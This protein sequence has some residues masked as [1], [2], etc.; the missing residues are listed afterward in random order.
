MVRDTAKAVK[1]QGGEKLTLVDDDSER[2]AI[3]CINGKVLAMQVGHVRLGTDGRIWN[4]D[5]ALCDMVLR[6]AGD[7]I[8]RS[9]LDLT[10]PPDRDACERRMRRLRDTSEPYSVVKRMM[11]PDGSPIWVAKTVGIAAFGDGPATALATITRTSDLTGSDT[12]LELLRQAKL[13]LDDIGERRQWMDTTIFTDPPTSILFGAYVAE[14]EGTI[15][16][17]DEMAERAGVARGVL[18]RWMRAMEDQGLIEAEGDVSLDAQTFGY[19]LTQR[20]LDRCE[21]YL[22]HRVRVQELSLVSA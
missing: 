12:P 16:R 11:L 9:I 14:A 13:L 7:L 22:M 5:A 6:T 1:E 19:R 3:I 20:S 2:I 15:A 4:V 18:I 21:S 17:I 10:Y 8:G